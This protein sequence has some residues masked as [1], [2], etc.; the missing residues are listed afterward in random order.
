MAVKQI[1]QALITGIGELYLQFIDREDTAKSAPVMVE[2]VYVV[3]SLDKVAVS[4]EL[5]EKKV[6]ASNLLHSDLSGVKFATNTIDALYLPSGFAEK[7]QGMVEVAGGWSMPT[8]P[9]KKYFRMAY[10]ITNEKGEMLVINY[11]KCSL[12]PVDIN[13]ETEREDI[14]EQMQQFNILSMPMIYK[15]DLQKQFVYHKMDLSV[16]ENAAKYDATKLLEKG[17]YDV[18]SAELCK[19]SED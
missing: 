7:A 9:E 4:L 17:W 1:K 11:P 3:P 16:P 10:S 19:K 14:N 15:G 13:G 18:A 6:Y 2:D 12:S 8:N 5:A